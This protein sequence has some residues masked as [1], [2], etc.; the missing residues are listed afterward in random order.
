MKKT[1]LC[2]VKLSFSATKLVKEDNLGKQTT[3]R[4]LRVTFGSN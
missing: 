3:L 2:L 4:R 1:K